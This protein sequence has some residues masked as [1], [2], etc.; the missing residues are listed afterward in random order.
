MLQRRIGL[1]DIRALKPGE[2]IWDGAVRRVPR[3]SPEKQDRF[4]HRCL[5]H[6]R[7]PAALADDWAPRLAL[8]ARHGA[9]CGKAHPRPRCRGR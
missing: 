7:G 4:L 8:D 3:A 5:S 9:R 1:K 6:G 2:I